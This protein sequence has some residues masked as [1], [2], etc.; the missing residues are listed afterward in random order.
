MYS[1]L[2]NFINI[3][4]SIDV[5]YNFNKM[6]TKKLHDHFNRCRKAVDKTQDPFIIKT[7]NKLAIE[8]NY[9]NRLV[10]FSLSTPI[11]NKIYPR[12]LGGE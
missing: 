6:K 5:T 8:G 2:I 11:L 10:N 9:L 3:Q 1:R 4:K 12:S 7:L